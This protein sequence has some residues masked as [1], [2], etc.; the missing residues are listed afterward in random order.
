MA[1]GG[2]D[3]LHPTNICRGTRQA[4]IHDIEALGD[5]ER[6]RA[7]PAAV[8]I[9]RWVTVGAVHAV[10]RQTSKTLRRQR[11]REPLVEATVP[12]STGDERV[13]FNL[14][15]GRA[16]IAADPVTIVA[17]LAGVHLAVAAA[18]QWS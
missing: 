4:R 13:D 5:V 16:P 2:D 12:T 14:A 3:D 18:W 6:T 10:D 17:F 9:A 8:E 7:V 1:T 11:D 15:I